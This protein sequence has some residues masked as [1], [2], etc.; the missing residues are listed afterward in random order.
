MAYTYAILDVSPACYREIRAKLEEAGYG[1]AFHENDSDEV[2]DMHGIALRASKAVMHCN[3]C[4]WWI[5]FIDRDRSYHGDCALFECRNKEQVHRESKLVVTR[6]GTGE[7]TAVT[8]A[9]FGC[10]QWKPCQ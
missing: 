9:D 3:T 5:P 2:I 4:G 1:H 10:V 8:C 6:T 7:A